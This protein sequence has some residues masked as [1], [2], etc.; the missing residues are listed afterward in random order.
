MKNKNDLKYQL[1]KQK[2]RTKYLIIILSILTIILE[3]LALF[4]VISFLYGLIP[5]C[6]SYVI[7]YQSQKQ[8]KNTIKK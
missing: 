2:Q 7:K 5:F 6:L 3:T 4:K 8:S 1:F